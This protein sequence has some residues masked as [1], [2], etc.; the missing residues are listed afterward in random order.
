MPSSAARALGVVVGVA[1]DMV[2]LSLG[3]PMGI[4]RRDTSIIHG[5]LCA[6]RKGLV[7]GL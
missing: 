6:A 7:W 1:S 3:R 2:P 5:G 4:H